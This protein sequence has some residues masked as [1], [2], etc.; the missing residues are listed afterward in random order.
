MSLKLSTGLRNALLGERDSYTATSLACVN[1]T[2]TITDSGNNLLDEGF[3]PEDIIDIA[4]FTLTDNNGLAEV[5]SVAS[6]GSSMVVS[7]L[8][9]ADEIEG[10]SVT[11]VAQSKGLKDIFRNHVIHVYSGSAPS[12]AD[13][14][15]TGTLLLKLTEESGAFTPGTATNGLNFGAISAGVMSKDAE[16]QSGVG[17][18]DGTA[19]YYR[20][21]DNGEVT[22][23]STTAKRMQ[24]TIGISSADFLMSSATISTSATTT[25]GTHNI[26]QPAS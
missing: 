3:R 19:G 25:L 23:E 16:I 4:G 17:L 10:D 6:D 24:G 14:V 22:G 8:T 18:D 2:N 20:V 7:G 5:V 26:T 15:E 11:I 12:S 21:Y 1:S 13:D 9:L